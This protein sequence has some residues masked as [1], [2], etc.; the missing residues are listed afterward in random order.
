M[1]IDLWK[2]EKYKKGFYLCNWHR[3]EL[4]AKK[5]AEGNPEHTPDWLWPPDEYSVVDRGAAIT[6]CDFLNLRDGC[7]VV[8]QHGE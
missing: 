7:E 4:A 6:M 2:I 3:R 8:L 1:S 5:D